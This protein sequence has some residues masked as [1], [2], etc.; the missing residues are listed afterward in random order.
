MPTPGGR[1]LPSCWGQLFSPG[2]LVNC[3]RT[4]YPRKACLYRPT[5]RGKIQMIALSAVTIEIRG[6]GSWRGATRGAGSGVVGMHSVNL[7]KMKVCSTCVARLWGAKWERAERRRETAGSGRGK[8]AR[9]G[10]HERARGSGPYAVP[11]SR[12]PRWISRTESSEHRLS[13]QEIKGGSQR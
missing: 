1:R 11:G 7:R 13:C 10:A 2:K 12:E 8:R 4:S 9:A 3:K 6:A 5:L